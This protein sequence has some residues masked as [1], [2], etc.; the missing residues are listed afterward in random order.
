MPYLIVLLPEQVKPNAGFSDEDEVGSFDIRPFGPYTSTQV[1]VAGCSLCGQQ[2]EARRSAGK[3][4]PS[5]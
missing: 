1:S 3:L 4:R 5:A 2:L